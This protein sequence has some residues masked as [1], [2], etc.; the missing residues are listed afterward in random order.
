M[1]NIGSNQF[2]N[3]TFPLV[4]QDHYFMLE[5]SHEKDV[6]TVLQLKDGHLI[7]EVLKN[8]PQ[9]NPSTQVT[10][11]PTGIITVS[12]KESGKFLYKIRPKSKNTSIFGSINGEETK[13]KITDT[14]IR[15]GTNSFQNNTVTGFSVGIMVNKDGG[16]AMGCGLPKEI[17]KLVS[18]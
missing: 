17:Q 12:D 15:V 2:K 3:V 6:W 7:I 11:N 1:A 9:Q 4:F 8:D 10:T 18:G 14:E 13:I 16:M 5:T